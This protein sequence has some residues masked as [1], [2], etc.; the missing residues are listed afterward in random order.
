MLAAITAS[1]LLAQGA[2]APKA[3]YVQSLTKPD[4]SVEIMTSAQRFVK[5][6]KPDVWL[7]GAMH[8][9]SKAYYTDLQKL[10]DEQGQVLYEGVKKSA[11]AT[12]KPVPTK[13]GAPTPIYKV[14]SDAIGLQFQLNE[15][16]YD[17]P[18]WTNAD[19]SFD[20]LD[21]INKEVG[22]GKPTEYDQVKQMLDPNSPQTKMLATMLATAT[23]GMKEALKLLI[24]KKASD[25]SV[26]LNPATE[27]VIL[28]ARNE[29]VM[30]ELGKAIDVAPA[31]KSIGVFY[32]ALHMGDLETSLKSKLGYKTAEQKWFVAA[33]ADP[34]KM[35]ETGKALLKA[36][37]AQSKPKKG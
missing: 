8:I 21:K 28:K 6:G 18:N 20:E 17:R 27:K 23:P 26:T 22:G 35:D 7:I 1:L 36:F 31:P 37:D 4:G 3:V 5:E 16:K 19:L 2:A 29:A 30:V 12:G 25:P 11:G 13:E 9:G 32:G 14:L 10:L 24:V 15:I 34:K 33:S